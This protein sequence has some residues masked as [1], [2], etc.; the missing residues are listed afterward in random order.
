MTEE[1]IMSVNEVAS[2]L[3]IK[4]QTIFSWISY[5]QLDAKYGLYFKLGRC[6]RFRKSKLLEWIEQGCPLVNRKQA[7][8]NK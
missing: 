1:V 7:K 3:N 8:L 6:V 2:Y 4:P 5:K